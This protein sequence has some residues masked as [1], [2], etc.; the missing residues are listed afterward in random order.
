MG[1][2]LTNGIFTVTFWRRQSVFF[3]FFGRIFTIYPEY[4]KTNFPLG[5]YLH[6]Y[7]WPM[8]SNRAL[9]GLTVHNMEP[10]TCDLRTEL[11]SEIWT[12]LSAGTQANRADP[13]QTTENAVSDLGLHCLLKLHILR[14]TSLYSETI[15]Q[16]G[17][18]MLW[19]QWYYRHIRTKLGRYSNYPNCVQ[20]CERSR[21]CPA[22]WY[23]AVHNVDVQ[24]P[25]H[26]SHASDYCLEL[27]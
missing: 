20:N 18:S 17:L 2:R 23:L 4:T 22:D 3:F 21:M 24:S 10:T 9:D 25:V 11:F 8:K 15:D 13:D 16:P 26:T 6:D 14:F 7:Q 5:W 1:K 19:L 12:K 27:I